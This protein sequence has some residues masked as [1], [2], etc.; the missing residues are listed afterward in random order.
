[1]L[2]ITF[3]VI[4]LMVGSAVIPAITFC[5]ELMVSQRGRV[6]RFCDLTCCLDRYWRM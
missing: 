6:G 4:P 2:H 1:M 3:I 5:H